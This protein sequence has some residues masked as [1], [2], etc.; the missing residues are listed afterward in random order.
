MN[1]NNFMTIQDELKQLLV[2]NYLKWQNDLGEIK[3]QREF[4]EEVLEIHEVSYSRYFNDRRTPSKKTLIAFAERTGDPRFYDLANVPRPD[5]DFAALKA[6]WK[7]IPEEKRHALREQGENY[8][9]DNH[10]NPD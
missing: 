1:Y 8:A 7:Y 5:P 4:A 2:E 3:T 10:R 6:I 9:E